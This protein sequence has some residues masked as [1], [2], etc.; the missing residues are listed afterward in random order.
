M[1]RF[2][3]NKKETIAQNV[4]YWAIMYGQRPEKFYRCGRDAQRSCNQSNTWFEKQGVSCRYWVKRFKFN[5]KGSEVD[6]YE[7]EWQR[8]EKK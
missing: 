5:F 4:F 7:H 6:I 2:M 1:T 3:S 8:K